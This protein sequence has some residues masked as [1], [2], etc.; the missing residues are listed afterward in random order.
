[1]TVVYSLKEFEG[2]DHLHIFEGV[3]TKLK[4]LECN[5]ASVEKSVCGK[6]AQTKYKRTGFGFQCKTARESLSLCILSVKPICASCEQ[7]IFKK[8]QELTGRV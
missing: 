2:L 7:H 6:V 3:V 8:Y 5:T 1:M 4:P